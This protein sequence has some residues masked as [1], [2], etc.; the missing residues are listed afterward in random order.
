MCQLLS[1]CI[2]HVKYKYFYVSLLLPCIPSPPAKSWHRGDFLVTQWHDDCWHPCTADASKH[3]P[4][5]THWDLC[6]VSL[7]PPHFSGLSGLP[8]RQRVTDFSSPELS[9]HATGLVLVLSLQI[10]TLPWQNSPHMFWRFLGVMIVWD[11]FYLSAPNTLQLISLTLH[12]LRW[13]SV[14]PCFSHVHR[15]LFQLL[16]MC[17]CVLVCVCP[18]ATDAWL[19]GGDWSSG[20]KGQ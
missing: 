3:F 13:G 20:G 1:C 18:E 10:Y 7:W 8:W 12:V 16:L 5:S 15:L 9:P 17:H 4:S 11:S 14:F 6:A 19:A 2:S